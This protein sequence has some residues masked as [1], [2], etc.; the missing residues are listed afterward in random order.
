MILQATSLD[1]LKPS[2]Q[3]TDKPLNY[4]RLSGIL[5]EFGQEHVLRH[6]SD[7]DANQRANL[8]EQLNG[9]DLAE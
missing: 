7:L 6:W 2:L 5:A 9:I 3:L 1:H 8:S 4:D